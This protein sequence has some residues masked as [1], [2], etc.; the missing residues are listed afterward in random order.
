MLLCPP[1]S[2]QYTHVMC[3]VV[4]EISAKFGLHAG[5]MKFNTQNEEGISISVM[6]RTRAILP[7][8][9]SVHIHHVK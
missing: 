8:Y 3:Y 7:V 5:N 2:V 4:R 6:L 1:F 9:T